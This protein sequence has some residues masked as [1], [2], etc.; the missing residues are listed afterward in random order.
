MR[1]VRQADGAGEIAARRIGSTVCSRTC[2]TLHKR[3]K[4]IAPIV[5]VD[6][7]D[8]LL[9]WVLKVAQGGQFIPCDKGGLAEDDVD[10][11][12][13]GGQDQQEV[14]RLF[15]P[16]RVLT[17]EVHLHAAALEDMTL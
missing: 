12:Q 1:L 8:H 6:M 15:T 5:E 17:M 9:I 4:V 13:N 16:K 11:D 10:T 14:V 3:K 2:N 7:D